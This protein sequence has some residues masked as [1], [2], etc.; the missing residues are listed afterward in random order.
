MNYEYL[1]KLGC[2]CCL[3]ICKNVIYI[4]GT[5]QKKKKPPFKK[6]ISRQVFLDGKDLQMTPKK[7]TIQESNICAK[8]HI[9]INIYEGNEYDHIFIL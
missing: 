1:D 5:T 2:Y 9:T 3:Q 8:D 6:L 4:I 7:N